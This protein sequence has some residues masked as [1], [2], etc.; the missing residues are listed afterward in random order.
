MFIVVL[1]INKDKMDDLIQLQVQINQVVKYCVT[2]YQ[3][4]RTQHGIKIFFLFDVKKNIL[5]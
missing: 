5:R 4:W 2:A 3:A 1:L